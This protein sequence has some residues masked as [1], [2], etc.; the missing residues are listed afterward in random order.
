MVVP[1]DVNEART[2]R[3]ALNGATLTPPAGGV[4]SVQVQNML[5]LPRMKLHC[6]KGQ[7]ASLRLQMVRGLE[8]TGSLASLER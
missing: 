4:K 8:V 6:V 5:F 3:G 7:T 2:R 1:A